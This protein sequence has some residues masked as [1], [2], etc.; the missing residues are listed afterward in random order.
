M[1]RCSGNAKP[2]RRAGGETPQVPSLRF[3][4]CLRANGDVLLTDVTPGSSDRDSLE[5]TDLGH[6]AFIIV[7]RSLNA[8]DYLDGDKFF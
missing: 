6:P 1:N 7:V 5:P 3:A 2:L 4:H 8:K